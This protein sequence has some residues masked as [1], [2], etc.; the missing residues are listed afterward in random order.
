M[1]EVW[2]HPGVS[3]R[4]SFGF[5]WFARGFSILWTLEH[6]SSGD[7]GNVRNGSRVLGVMVTSGV[8]KF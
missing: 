3:L 2:E 5:G 1:L 7:P 4:F 8:S 6:V